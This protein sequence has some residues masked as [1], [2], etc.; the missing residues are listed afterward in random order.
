M[1]HINE[2]IF[3]FDEWAADQDAHFRDYFY[4]TLLPEL[5][6]KGK[7]V[8]AI[9]HDDRYFNLA[10]RVV[11]LEAGRIVAD[12]RPVTGMPA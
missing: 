1:Y 5:K 2:E 6:A 11:K 12:T 9:S 7:T 4:R 8:I 10:D 3:F